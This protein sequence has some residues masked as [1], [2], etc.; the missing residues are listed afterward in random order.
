MIDDSRYIRFR[1]RDGRILSDWFD[2]FDAKALARIYRRVIHG[3]QGL[4]IEYLDNDKD[5]YQV[6]ID[7]RKDEASIAAKQLYD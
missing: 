6:R 7:V 3:V 2:S 5:F 1:A 4:L